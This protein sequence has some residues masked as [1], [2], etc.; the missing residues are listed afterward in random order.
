[1]RVFLSWSELKTST[2]YDVENIASSLFELQFWRDLIKI[3]V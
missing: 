2:Q 3:G 1:M